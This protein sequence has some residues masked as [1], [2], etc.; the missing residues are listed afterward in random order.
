[1]FGFESSLCSSLFALMCYLNNH[2]IVLIVVYLTKTAI[3]S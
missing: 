3:N 2:E 1:M